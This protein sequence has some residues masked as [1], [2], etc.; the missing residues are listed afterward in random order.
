M[1]NR[2][3]NF[4]ETSSGDLVVFTYNPSFPVGRDDFYHKGYRIPM[5]FVLLLGVPYRI[6]EE[7]YRVILDALE[8]GHNITTEELW[9]DFL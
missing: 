2:V 5:Y 7:Y 9:R 6:D 1:S 4:R 8:P 3:L